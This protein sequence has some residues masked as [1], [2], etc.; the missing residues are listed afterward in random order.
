M[1]MSQRKDQSLNK[2]RFYPNDPLKIFSCEVSNTYGFLKDMSIFSFIIGL[3]SFFLAELIALLIV[4]ISWPF[5]MI[6][7][8]PKHYQYLHFNKH[9]LTF[10]TGSLR[11]LLSRSLYKQ[12]KFQYGDLLSICFNRWEKRR[13]GGVKD[14]FG[15]VEIV[16][17]PI[18]PAFHFLTTNIDL[19]QLVKFFDTHS[20]H[21]KV[22][23]RRTK[24]ELMLI[25]PRSPRFDN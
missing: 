17:D 12:Y 6:Y 21:T 24:G 23:K 9:N 18:I 7:L 5:L 15:K 19:N 8:L 25:F 10:G 2:G 11:F 1:Q 20:F 14:Y 13:R 16:Y 4:P 22:K 3:F